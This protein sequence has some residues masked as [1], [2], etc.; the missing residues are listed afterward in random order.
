M[1]KQQPVPLTRE[2]LTIYFRAA[3]TLVHRRRCAAAILARLF[4]DIFRLLRTDGLAA[5]VYTSE[6]RKR[7][8]Q[9]RQLLLYAISFLTQRRNY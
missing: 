9:T 8:I 6:R 4:A 3:L 7:R 1:F 2:T 5:A